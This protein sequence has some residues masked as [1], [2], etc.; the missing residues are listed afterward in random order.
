MIV[1]TLIMFDFFIHDTIIARCAAFKTAMACELE[2]GSKMSSGNENNSN[3]DNEREDAYG[4]GYIE[5]IDAAKE[6]LKEKTIAMSDINVTVSEE[7][8]GLIV[9]CQGKNSPLTSRIVKM[10]QI[11]RIAVV[12]RNR[13]D[14]FIRIVSAI[15][16]A[17]K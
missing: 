10:S 13:P 11:D 17:V 16:N 15:R 9:K 8:D 14:D 5:Y 6:Y 2:A 3:D 7:K 4:S 12:K 1:V